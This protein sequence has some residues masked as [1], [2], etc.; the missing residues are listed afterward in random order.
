MLPVKL[1]GQ[2]LT[3]NL[4]A[5][6]LAP[7]T[8]TAKNRPA[9]MTVLFGLRMEQLQYFWDGVA[10]FDGGHLAAAA[11]EFDFAFGQGFFADGQTDGET[12]PTRNP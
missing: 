2:V 5:A 3:M 11:L 12:R 9:A 8:K 4:T 7:Q 10:G 1:A 6:L